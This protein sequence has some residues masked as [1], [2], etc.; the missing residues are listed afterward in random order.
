MI[1]DLKGP[2]SPKGLKGL[3]IIVVII[4]SKKSWINPKIQ[5]KNSSL[6]GRGMFALEKI[7][8]GEDILTFGGDYIDKDEA[9]E[10]KAKGKLVMQWDEN[11]F[12]AE[13]RGDDDTYFLNHSCNGNTWMKDAFTLIAH[14]D[15]LPGEEV[16][17][18][19]ILWEADEN[20]I[21]KWKCQCG[22][23]KCRGQVTGKD[24]QQS[25]LQ[26]RYKNHFSP[27]INKRITTYQKNRE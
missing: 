1:K 17:A 21:S 2:K 4:T 14:H 8:A 20:Y 15:I 5:I 10:E 7:E 11:L 25:E 24:W 19:Y 23:H 16:T 18:D 12:T 9:L 26:E 27:L 6:G 3:N 22:E 13:E